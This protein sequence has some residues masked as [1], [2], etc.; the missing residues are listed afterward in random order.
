MREM[1]DRAWIIVLLA[2][3]CGPAVALGGD[4]AADLHAE[5]IDQFISKCNELGKFNGTILV[6]EEGQVIY[7]KAFGFAN[8]EWGVRNHLATKFRIGSLTKSF[9][10]VL[11]MQLIEDGKLDLAG[12]ITDYLPDYPKASGDRIT[13]HHLL[14]H[15]SG[16]PDYL[17]E[18]PEF[19]SPAS[20]F[21]FRY[22]TAKELVAIFS[23]LDLKFEPGEQFEY[24]NS[25]YIVLGAIIEEVTG[26]TYEEVLQERI[27]VPLGMRHSGYAR[28]EVI[29][30][31][32]ASGHIKTGST[33]NHGRFDNTSLVFSAGAMYSTVGDLFKWDRALYGEKLLPEQPR[34][35]M[36][37][38][39]YRDKRTGQGHGYG[40]QVGE[41]KIAKDTKVWFV[42][43]I[44]V[45]S[46]FFGFMFR[47]TDD[48]DLLVFLTNT[49]VLG[50]GNARDIVVPIAS[51]LND[52]PYLEPKFMT[53]QP[54]RP[55]D[56]RSQE[57]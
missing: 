49:N 34:E 38:Q 41:L 31:G 44:G 27:L 13:I 37:Q 18:T 57:D 48:G 4:S 1:A 42:S 40:W 22:H 33:F 43:Q 6:A 9:T 46:G 14:A 32:R 52:E 7:H 5:L 20:C 12:H 17:R 55:S 3:L 25:G 15:R 28:P 51:I 56:K 19:T 26:K 29:L 45:T 30:P 23:E 24:S 36:F 47:L 50:K 2:L 54:D 21:P 53:Q 8:L 10:A 11:V 35:V 16:I 39:H